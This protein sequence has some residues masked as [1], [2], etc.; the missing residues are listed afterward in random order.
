MFIDDS[1]AARVSIFNPVQE[2]AFAG[3]ALVGTV[4]YLQHE[5]GVEV[6]SIESAGKTSEAWET[7]GLTWLQAEASLLPPWR[8]EQVDDA[9]QV[10]HITKNEALSK[11]HTVVWA[12]ENEPERVIR[13]RTFAPDWGIPEDEANGSGSML[14]AL[15][16]G[17]DITVVHGKGSVIDVRCL[18]DGVVAVG[19]RCALLPD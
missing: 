6:D 16:L 8:L 18:D 15:Q 1:E 3:H 11:E 14:L 7:D 10:Q 19:G 17:R 9:S 13:A 4:W 2:V 5:Q 12:F